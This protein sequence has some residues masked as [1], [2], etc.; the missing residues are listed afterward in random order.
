MN[1]TPRNPTGEARN[2]IAA[3]LPRAEKSFWRDCVLH[4]H[5]VLANP[6]VSGFEGTGEFNGLEGR[7]PTFSG[8]TPYPKP[9]DA[10]W[11]GKDWS[12]ADVRADSLPAGRIAQ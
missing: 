5:P 1:N 9:T 10:I 11:L 3:S 12:W 8:K 4:H 2:I 6:V 7:L